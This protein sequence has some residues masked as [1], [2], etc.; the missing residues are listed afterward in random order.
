MDNIKKI[1]KSL[2]DFW[3]YLWHSKSILSWILL[4]VLA[5]I[6]VKFIFFP[7]LYLITGAQV[8]LMVI[9]SCS[10]NHNGILGD[11][12]NWWEEYGGWYQKN[13]ITKEEFKEFAYTRGMKM[14]DIVLVWNH[15]DIKLGDVIIFSP[16]KES[17]AQN[18]IIHRVISLDPLATKG[19]H[20]IGQLTLNNNNERTDET[21]IKEN[22]VLGKAIFK[23]PRLGWAKLFFVKL[24]EIMIGVPQN[25]WC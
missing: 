25:P 10:M 9:E 7:S 20:N 22:Q 13:S 12:D 14:G 19:D 17:S 16:N 23:I 15:G 8:P 5:Y 21:D 3:N 4:L 11:F 2:K 24:V 1:K 18:P 6:I